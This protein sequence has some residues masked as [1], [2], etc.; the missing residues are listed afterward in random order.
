LVNQKEII[1]EDDEVERAYGG[2]QNNGSKHISAVSGRIT[3]RITA[4]SLEN[5]Q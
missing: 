3:V 5:N 4:P 2:T 1:N